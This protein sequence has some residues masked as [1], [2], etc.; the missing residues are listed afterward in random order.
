MNC[1]NHVCSPIVGRSMASKRCIRDAPQDTHLFT[2][3][4]SKINCSL[5]K[6]HFVQFPCFLW[7]AG[8]QNECGAYQLGFC[9]FF[10][11]SGLFFLIIVVE[12]AMNHLRQEIDIYQVMEPVII[13]KVI[14]QLIVR[15]LL[16]LDFDMQITQQCMML[17][18]FVHVQC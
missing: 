18:L 6:L 4:A 12:V 10:L 3:N 13:S 1:H 7:E 14:Q 17:R 5:A 8:A 15:W 11:S 9:D 2:N 16:K